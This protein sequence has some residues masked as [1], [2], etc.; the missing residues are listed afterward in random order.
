MVVGLI[1]SCINGKKRT[2]AKLKSGYIY[3]YTSPGIV[4]I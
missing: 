3:G 1:K 2:D 4:S